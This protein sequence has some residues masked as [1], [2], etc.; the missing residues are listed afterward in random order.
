[1]NHPSPERIAARWLRQQPA[2][3]TVMLAMERTAGMAVEAQGAVTATSA[4]VKSAQ[5]K[6]EEDLLTALGPAF[7]G[8]ILNRVKRDGTKAHITLI[9]PPDLKLVVA[10]R[11]VKDGVSKSE[12]VRRLEAELPNTVLG[13]TWVVK[14]YGAAK[15]GAKVAYYVT[16]DW[17]DGDDFRTSLG[18]NRGTQDFH[19]TVGFGDGG[20]VFDVPKNRVLNVS[21]LRSFLP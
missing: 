3:P 16:L 17:P 13:D 12:A 14:G 9:R 18:L 4:R 21:E 20:D 5:K 7:E 1:M 15:V 8:F 19:I 10:Q 11:V 6:A 2:P